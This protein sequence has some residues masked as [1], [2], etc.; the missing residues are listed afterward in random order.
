MKFSNNY[1]L[2]EIAGEKVVVKQ[3][4]HGVDMTK[5]ISFNESASALWEEFCNKEFTVED[6]AKFL[7]STYGISEETATKDAGIWVNKLADCGAIGK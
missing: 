6:A 5:I 4:T 1:I 2:R 3:G 7:M